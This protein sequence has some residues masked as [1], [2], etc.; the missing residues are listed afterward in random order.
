MEQFSSIGGMLPEQVWDYADFPQEGMYFGQSAGSAQPLVW[1]HSEY[2][3]LLRSV[4]DGEVFDCISVVKERYG[5]AAGTRS[6]KSNVEIFQT[7]R[8]VR[9]IAAGMIL[10]VV[11]TVRFSVL[12]TTDDWATKTEKESR[13]AG[14]A[15]S[16]ADIATAAGQAGKIVFTFYW[17][18]EGKWLGKNF[19]VAVV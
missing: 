7:S 12:Y 11:D 8:P 5:V 2:L 6:F 15:G 3:K 17:P 4:V 14:Y 19:E 13:P 10:R 16:F 9:E 1:A 18:G